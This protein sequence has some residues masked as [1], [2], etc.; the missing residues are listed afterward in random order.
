MLH[1]DCSLNMGEVDVVVFGVAVCEEGN[2]IPACLVL[3]IVS[4]GPIREELVVR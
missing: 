2:F 1:I 3:I 4:D